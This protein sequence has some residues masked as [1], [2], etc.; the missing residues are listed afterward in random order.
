MSVND[1]QD[2]SISDLKTSDGSQDTDIKDLQ[3]KVKAVESNNSDQ[4]ASISALK[5]ADEDATKVIDGLDTDFSKLGDRVTKVED[6]QATDMT[7]LDTHTS[8]IDSLKTK[9]ASNKEA[10]A[11][12]SK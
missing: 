6:Q 7:T 9:I 8:D 5:T 2:A 11:S 10:I 3:D 12:L 4:D 1:K